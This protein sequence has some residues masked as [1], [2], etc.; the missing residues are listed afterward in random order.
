M[1][2]SDQRPLRVEHANPSKR[3]KEKKKKRKKEKKKKAINK[4]ARPRIEEE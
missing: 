4:T 3:K 2:V 1:F